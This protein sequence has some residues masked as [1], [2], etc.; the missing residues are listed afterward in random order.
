MVK[1][2]I[3]TVCASCSTAGPTLSDAG[4]GAACTLEV[5]VGPYSEDS[6]SAYQDGD[7]AELDPC[8]Q[9]LVTTFLQLRIADTTDDSVDVYITADVDGQTSWWPHLYDL[10]EG[11]DGARYTEVIPFGF[12]S[13]LIADLIGH[14]ALLEARATAAGCTGRDEVRL[15]LVDKTSCKK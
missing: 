8:F 12:N 15:Q 1:V 6:F 13:S 2:V 5:A 14:D 9:S 4:D 10:S 11:A 7:S 3:M